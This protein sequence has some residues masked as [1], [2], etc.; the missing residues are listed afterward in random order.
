MLSNPAFNKTFDVAL[1]LGTLVGAVAYFRRDIAHYLRAFFASIKRR[2]VQSLDERVA[3]ALVLGTIPGVIAGVALESVI[4]DQLGQPWMIAIALG[5]FG[6]VLWAVDR[7]APIRRRFDSVRPRDGVTL[8]VA[9]AAALMPGVSRSGITITAGRLMGIDREGAARFS[10]LL[11]LPIIFG[12][13]LYKGVDVVQNGLPPGTALP[14]L[15]GIVASALSGFATIWFLL[16]Y[17]RRKDFTIFMVYRL[18]AAA[19]V[20]ALIATGLLPPTI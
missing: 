18:A 1:H 19:F 5:V 20:L 3:W 9:Q 8:G 15:A 13:G 17:L 11:S 6:V 4:Q 14:F 12:A 7:R 2:K 16:G 10:F